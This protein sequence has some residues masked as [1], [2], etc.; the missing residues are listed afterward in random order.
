MHLLSWAFVSLIISEL[1]E[2]ISN[3]TMGL[4]KKYGD[5]LKLMHW[6]IVLTGKRLR[7]LLKQREYICQFEM[8]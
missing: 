4:K 8:I 6:L 5:W 7:P 2:L 3:S 1:I